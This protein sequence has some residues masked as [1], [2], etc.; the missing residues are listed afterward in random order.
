MHGEMRDADRILVGNP[1]QKRPLE[2]PKRTQEDKER[3]CEGVDW[4][5]LA[6][7]GTQWWVY[8]NMVMNFGFHKRWRISLLVEQ[9]SA[10]HE[11]LCSVELISVF[12]FD[13]IEQ[14]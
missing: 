8:V 2:R 11:G 3:R 13:I 9:L 10:S 1:E 6:K 14:G 7:D 4:I 12:L 5:R